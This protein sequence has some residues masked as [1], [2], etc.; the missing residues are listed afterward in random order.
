M[1][2]V[3]T[4]TPTWKTIDGKLYHLEPS[5]NRT[6]KHGGRSY[7]NTVREEVDI[8]NH[9]VRTKTDKI[10]RIISDDF[11]NL[12]YLDENNDFTSDIY[13]QKIQI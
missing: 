7:T 1:F 13:F 4:P 9:G 8:I 3:T 12:Y 6:Y 10:K 11:G 2:A 5:I